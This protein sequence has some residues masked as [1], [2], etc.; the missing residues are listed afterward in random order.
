MQGSDG[1][2]NSQ[3]LEPG[4]FGYVPAG[5][6]HA[7]RVEEQA[8]VLGVLSGGFERFSQRMGTPV[9]SAAPG[10]PP[11]VPDLDRIMAAG[12]RHGTT[13]LPGFDW[14]DA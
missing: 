8:R 10:Q 3:L 7:Y 13:F 14:P 1:Q 5:L 9:D 2:K 6:V 11:F 12:Q 4:D